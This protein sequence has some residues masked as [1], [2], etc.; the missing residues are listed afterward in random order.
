MVSVNRA[1]IDEKLLLKRAVCEQDKKALT[2]LYAKYYPQVKHYIASHVGCVE[3]AEDLVQDVFVELSKGKG[4][5]DGRGNVIGYLL[6][7]AKKIIH[8]YHRR[9]THSVRTIPIVSVDKVDH[10]YHN[11][12]RLDPVR[13]ISAQELK[14]AIEDTT[15]QL[16]PKAREA[17]RL[18]YIDG[19]GLRESAEKAG[20]SA[21]TFC[22]RV[23]DAK[24]ALKKYKKMFESKL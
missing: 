24:K 22:Q 7:I 11:Q 6:G 17:I 19:L 18:R 20:C 15:A 23:L 16:P 13:Q 5:Y 21:H 3:D 12:Q 2:I 4:H 1:N 9:K 14:T 8:R 10:S